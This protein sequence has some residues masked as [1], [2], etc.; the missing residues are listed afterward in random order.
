MVLYN[1]YHPSI[2]VRKPTHPAHDTQHVVIDT[3]EADLCSVC[4]GC[5]CQL[6][7]CVVDTRHIDGARRLVLQRVLCER[8]H[9]DTDSGRAL[10]VLVRL[11]HIEVASGL[12]CETVVAVQS[13]LSSAQGVAT[14][15]CRGTVGVV[16]VAIHVS[17]DVAVQLDNPCQILHRVVEGQ[18]DLVVGA[19]DR[20]VTAELQL[21]NQILVIDLCE[22]TALISVQIHIIHLQA[23]VGE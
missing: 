6:H 7:L 18:L 8:I 23:C 11:H 10:E 9:V 17:C 21:L 2:T 5:S 14:T 16:R 22:A 1:I 12:G 13:Q 15:V 20:L 4:A 3:V 19:R